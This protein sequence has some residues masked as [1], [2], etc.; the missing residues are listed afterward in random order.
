MSQIF[1]R[2]RSSAPWQSLRR[3]STWS[4]SVSPKATLCKSLALQISR[5]QPVISHCWQRHAAHL[6]SFFHV[7]LTRQAWSCH[8]DKGR[9]RTSWPGQGD[10]GGEGAHLYL[11]QQDRQWHLP[12]RGQQP[13]RDQQ[14]WICP[15]RLRWVQGKAGAGASHFPVR[16]LKTFATT[17]KESSESN[18]KKRLGGVTQM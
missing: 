6:V 3:A 9:R 4:W 16:N 5:R 10:C 12:L 13:A 2:S 15:L 17:D 7:A 8:M 18:G 11:T 1:L 14:R